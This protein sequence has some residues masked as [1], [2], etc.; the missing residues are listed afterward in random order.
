MIERTNDKYLLAP[1]F[2]IYMGDVKLMSGD[3]GEAEQNYQKAASIKPDYPKSWLAL[4]D[5]YKKAGR[6][7]AARE[8]LEKG[9]EASPEKYKDYLRRRLAELPTEDQALEQQPATERKAAK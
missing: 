9:L 5:L 6:T 2:Y 8:A 4:S 1:D 3:R 7:K